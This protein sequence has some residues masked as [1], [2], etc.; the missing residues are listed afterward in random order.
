MMV[1]MVG[2]GGRG[3]SG[4]VPMGYESR[5]EPA[6]TKVRAP[7]GVILLREERASGLGADVGAMEG[8]SRIELAAMSMEASASET[9]MR[10]GRGP[11]LIKS[12]IMSDRIMWW[13]SGL[14][15]NGREK[16]LQVDPEGVL[17]GLVGVE[18]LSRRGLCFRGEV[19]GEGAGMRVSGG[20]CLSY[21]S[22]MGVTP[23]RGE[24]VL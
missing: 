3:R 7:A 24:G 17:M 6:A 1:G 21:P 15:A 13:A 14:D 18:T 12:G 19:G 8:E 2:R 22:V 20:D 4:G 11:G 9:V 5:I 16:L 23:L 10:G